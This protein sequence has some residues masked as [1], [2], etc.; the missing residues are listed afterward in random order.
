MTPEA[1]E[2]HRRYNARLQELYAAGAA[3]KSEVVNGSWLRLFLIWPVE[4]L[5]RLSDTDERMLG[6]RIHPRTTLQAVAL[7]L[8]TVA[9]FFVAA[10]II[11]GNGALILL[12]A[13][14]VLARAQGPHV[15]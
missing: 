4:C 6:I 1:E 15:A 7:L 14:V 12:A 3:Y 13:L 2:W 10:Y 5:F 8:C 9:A 11:T